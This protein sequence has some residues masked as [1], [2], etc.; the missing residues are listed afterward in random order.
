MLLSKKSYFAREAVPSIVRFDDINRFRGSIR[1][2]WWV[3]FQFKKHPKVLLQ[4]A[5]PLVTSGCEFRLWDAANF[6]SRKCT[7]CRWLSKRKLRFG[8]FSRAKPY[9]TNQMRCLQQT[10]RSPG[11]CSLGLS[12]LLTM[13][14]QTVTVPNHQFCRRWLAKMWSLIRQCFRVLNSSGT[15]VLL[16]HFERAP[17]A[18]TILLGAT[19]VPEKS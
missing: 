19:W 5:N 10:G 7:I 9:R 15:K 11:S 13:H 18:I 3:Y 17:P 6:A 12:L 1:E 2:P 14:E 8:C 4:P 16:N